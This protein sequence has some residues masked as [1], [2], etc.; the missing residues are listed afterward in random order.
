[1]SNS[2]FA[3]I[4]DHVPF[5]VSSNEKTEPARNMAPAEM[6]RLMTVRKKVR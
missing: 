2:A 3:K 4:C 1:M 6:L 5:A